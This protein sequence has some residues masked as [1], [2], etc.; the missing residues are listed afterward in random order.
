MPTTSRDRRFLQPFGWKK[1]GE[2][3]A[4]VHNRPSEG[5]ECDIGRKS[6]H[7]SPAGTDRSIAEIEIGDSE[8]SATVEME[9]M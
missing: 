4:N 2:Y 5:G 8:I 7:F 6:K 3:I 1:R 9:R